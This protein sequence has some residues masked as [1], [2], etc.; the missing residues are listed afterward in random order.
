MN[1]LTVLSIATAVA[2][3]LYSTEISAN[4]LN[5][6]F[7][8]VVEQQVAQFHLQSQQQARLDL[9]KAAVTVQA[10]RSA[11]QFATDMQL[12]L[13]VAKTDIAAE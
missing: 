11:E 3:N 12:G 13:H 2:A 9:L 8:A 4:E 6:Q 10:Q 1:T 7:R 5:T